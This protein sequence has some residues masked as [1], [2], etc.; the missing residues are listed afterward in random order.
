VASAGFE[1]ARRGER[2][3]LWIPSGL[4]PRFLPGGLD[5]RPPLIAFARLRPGQTATQVERQLRERHANE[6]VA[7][8]L[9][10]LPL[11][12][13]FG[14]PESRTI[15]I[16]EG[17][18]L[19][20][21]AVLASLVLLGGC[22]TLAA[23]V[24]VHI[25]RRRG[26]TAI[27]V[28]LGASRMRLVAE[29]SKELGLIAITGTV[30]AVVVAALGL[31]TLPSL[32]LPGSVDLGRLDLSI[33]WRV[34]GVAISVSALTLIAAG[35]LPIAWF[36]RHTRVGELWAGPGATA[37]RASQR[38]RQTLLTVQVSAGI[39]VLVAAGLFVRAVLH[40]FG[41]APGF[42][43]DR[44]VFVTVQVESQS[45]YPGTA[46]M[47]TWMSTVAERSARAMNALRALPGVEEV[48]QGLPPIGREEASRPVD[49]DTNGRRESLTL[50]RLDGSPEMLSALG[51]PIVAG[52]SLTLADQMARPLPAIVTASLARRLWPA[53]GPLGQILGT[54]RDGRLVIVGVARDFVV[55]STVRPPAGVIVTAR[56]LSSNQARLIV[57]AAHPDALVKAIPEAIRSV[58]P[59]VQWVSVTTGRE[60]VA[61]D[62]GRQ[63][64]G[65]WFFSGFG[66]AALVLAV[67]GTFGLVAYLAES[68]RREF[69]IRV[70]MGAGPGH[71]LRHGL[72]TA[73]VPVSIGVTI[74]L[75]CAA[76]TSRLFTSVLVGVSPLD[77]LTYISIGVMV[78]GC[79]GLAAL[80]AAWR[81]RR[82]RPADLLRTN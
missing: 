23:L 43:V 19:A 26:E 32:S 40:G 64:L 49:V 33:D 39:I 48:A 6:S 24:L 27:R 21:V 1:G 62:L 38:V 66:L 76:W 80:G 10:V 46:G 54:S 63:R 60:V 28:A 81:L 78:V 11:K 68:R 45:S 58:L 2:A 3:D 41:G 30:G 61:R 13:I 53:E 9:A 77:A 29:R 44:T 56:H 65:A 72:S 37:S 50:G 55:G 16:R 57:R 67:I 18:A 51:V 73:L 8:R 47:Y 70:A 36:T 4:L 82:V 59:G 75:V 69:G 42:D 20:I 71:L 7:D 74:G 12:D 34:L 31:Q 17:N 25:E 15:A 52:R 79:A 5:Q 35:W 22:A 14:A